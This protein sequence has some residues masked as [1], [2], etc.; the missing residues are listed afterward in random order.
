MWQWARPREQ[1]QGGANAL[2]Q[3]HLFSMPSALEFERRFS[4]AQFSR[5]FVRCLTFIRSSIVNR[6]GSSQESA[7]ACALHV[8]N[9]TFPRAVVAGCALIDAVA[10]RAAAVL[11]YVIL[12]D[13]LGH[14][15]TRR[16][17]RVVRSLMLADI[18]I[19]SLLLKAC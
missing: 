12:L 5:R 3:A 4:L 14:V 6:G 2:T 10:A 15:L 16:V 1:F 18:C 13:V 19:N 11:Q 7:H 8:A 9:V 17:Y